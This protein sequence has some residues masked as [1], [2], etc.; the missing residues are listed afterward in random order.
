MER[1][2]N[3]EHRSHDNRAGKRVSEFA[4]QLIHRRANLCIGTGKQGAGDS[5]QS[6]NRTDTRYDNHR[7]HHRVLDGCWAIFFSQEVHDFAS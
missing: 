7:Q 5:T 4:M 1:H 6:H 3:L 2:S